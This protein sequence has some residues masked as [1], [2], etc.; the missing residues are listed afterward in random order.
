MTILHLVL[1]AAAALFV[2]AAIGDVRRYLIPNAFSLGLAA[3]F[4]VYAFLTPAGLSWPGHLTAGTAAFAVGAGLFYMGAMGGGDVKLLAAAAL[5]AGPQGLADLLLVVAVAGGAVALVM[6]AAARLSRT[7]A[8]APS[9][10]AAPSAAKQR[11]PYGVAIAA[12]GLWS[13]AGLAAG[14]GV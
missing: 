9:G 8:T 1:A 11:V 7:P 2:F 10:D 12:G 3:L 14:T 4:G 5:W 6:L 13:L